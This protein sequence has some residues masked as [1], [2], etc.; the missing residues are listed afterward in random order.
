MKFL[1]RHTLRA[2]AVL[3]TALLTPSL[4]ASAQTDVTVAPSV[5]PSYVLSP[6]DQVSIVVLGHTDLGTSATISPDGTFYY[7]IVGTVHAAGLTVDGLKTA[8][9]RGLSDQLNQPQ[10]TVNVTQ[11]RPRKISVLGAVHAPGQYDVRPGTHLL[12]IMA[13]CGGPA[14]DAA[15]TQATLVMDGGKTSVPIDMP[16]L[17]S[18]KTPDQNLPLAAGDVLLVQAREAA[19]QQVQVMGEVGHPGAFTVPPD[20]LPVVSALVQAGGPTPKAAL[21]RAQIMRGGKI[22]VVDL[23][24]SQSTLA[25]PIGEA[26]LLPGDVLLVPAN[27]ARVALLGEFHTP[28]T[29][30]YPDG[31]SLTV[32]SA[33]TMVGGTTPD[34]DKKN[35]T[36]L[37]LGADGKPVLVAVNLDGVLKGNGSAATPLQPGDLLYVPTKSHSSGFNPLSA[38]SLLPLLSYLR[39]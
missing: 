13:A 3:L 35:A 7:P 12:D 9:T 2:A 29:F 16:G 34:A 39:L 36:I 24:P 27:T 17:L 21:S 31:G 23:R 38:L 14:Q 8:L 26:R 11:S 4:P 30:D 6:D 25:D 5:A 20:G 33:L 22:T 32:L 37:R 19:V 15:L 18:G 10:V 1:N 28:G